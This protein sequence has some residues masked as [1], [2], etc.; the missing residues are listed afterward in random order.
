M[1]FSMEMTKNKFEWAKWVIALTERSIE[2][3]YFIIFSRYIRAFEEGLNKIMERYKGHELFPQLMESMKGGKRLRPVLLMLSQEVCGGGEDAIPAAVAVELLH[4]VSIIHDDIIDEEVERRGRPPM[5]ISA[6]LKSAVLSA[7][8]AFSVI[9]DLS[10]KYRMWRIVKLISRTASEMS[11]GELMELRALEE[12]EKLSLEE[13]L[14]IISLKTA[15]LF[16]AAARIGALLSK[17]GPRFARELASFGH[18]LGMAYQIRDDLMDLGKKGE[19]ASLLD[20]DDK[21]KVL[22]GELHKY[23][24]RAL[25][26]LEKLPLNPSTLLLKK[27]VLDFVAPVKIL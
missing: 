19:L 22:V 16:E 13:Y 11:M 12:G 21:A 3:E 25:E 9:F 14:R 17:G 15:S 26:K 6:G 2:H 18:N 20:V 10:S 23:V 27:L 7:D 5:Y 24:E 1:R 4:T 8:Y